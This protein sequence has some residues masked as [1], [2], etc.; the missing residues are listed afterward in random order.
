MVM[1]T[2]I[3][4]MAI[5]IKQTGKLDIL[6]VFKD[7]FSYWKNNKK[8]M[9]L[10][11]MI[12]F[13]F[14]AFGLFVV[15]SMSNPLFLLWAAIYYVFWSWFFRFVFNRKPYYQ[16]K[17][18]ADSLVPSTKIFV[19]TIVFM[20]L[21][22]SLPWLL[23]LLA[24]PFNLSE[25]FIV[26][27]DRYVQFLES[28]KEGV[29]FL[30]SFI[31]IFLA[32]VIFYRPFY[33]WISSIIGRSGSIKFAFS[34]TRGNYWNFLMLGIIMNASFVILKMMVGFLVKF[35]PVGDYLEL[36]NSFIFFAVSSP[37]IV[38]Y[39]LYIAKSYETFFVVDV[40]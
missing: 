18:L 30:L 4:V 39:N 6:S 3:E 1:L 24:I 31:F 10:F 9:N 32:P 26:I 36:L 13:L 28:D 16:S 8:S 23:S 40:Q 29:E 33:A 7:S 12:N 25:K 19:L 21:I 27:M 5:D 15:G 20:L 11:T 14:L 2:R 37:L 17:V 35:I 38:Y 34:R 22:L